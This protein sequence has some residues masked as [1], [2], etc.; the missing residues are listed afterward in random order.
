MSKAGPIILIEDDQDDKSIFEE[1]LSDLNVSNKLVWFRDTPDAFEYLKSTDQKPFMIIC[2]V[3]LPT[4][5]GIRFK[6]NIDDHPELRKKSIPFIFFSTSASRTT[7]NEAYTQM[8][9]QGFFQKPSRVSE[10][11]HIL[12]VAVTYWRL[13]RHPNSE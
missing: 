7:V 11:R 5:S 3:N 10:I 13:C 6:S 9:V 8:T 12:D 2:D 4:M 1:I